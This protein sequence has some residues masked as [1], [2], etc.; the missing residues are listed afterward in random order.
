MLV[1]ALGYA[2]KPKRKKVRKDFG[3]VVSFNK[4]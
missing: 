1:I 4:Y 2:V 3:K